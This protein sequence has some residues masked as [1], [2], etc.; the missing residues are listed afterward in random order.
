M[1]NN[2]IEEFCDRVAVAIGKSP[3]EIKCTIMQAVNANIHSPEPIDRLTQSMQE[4]AEA[5]ERATYELQNYS[6]LATSEASPPSCIPT[7]EVRARLRKKRKKSK[8]R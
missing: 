3:Q 6:E 4:F 1:E 8:R 2:E 5:T 7:N